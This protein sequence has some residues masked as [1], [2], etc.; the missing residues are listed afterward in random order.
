MPT[1]NDFT[2]PYGAQVVT[3]YPGGSSFVAE[4]VTVT[5]ASTQIERYTELGI[6]ASQVI[7][8]T[9]SKGSGT[10]QL[11]TSQTSVPTIGSTFTL[12]RNGTP[13]ATVG[14]V[15]TDVGEVE[16]QKDARKVTLGF[17]VRVAS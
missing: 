2:V 14:C 11:A 3:V 4:N 16:N 15:V 9:F 12:V 6:P 8:P 17:R 10:F 1:Y 13:T 5:D 7:I